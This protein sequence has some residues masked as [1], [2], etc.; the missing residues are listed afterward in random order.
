M[1]FKIIIWVKIFYSAKDN[2]LSR[3]DILLFSTIP[4]V[5]FK[6]TVKTTQGKQS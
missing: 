5:I 6:H 2:H 1:S 3:N 4:M